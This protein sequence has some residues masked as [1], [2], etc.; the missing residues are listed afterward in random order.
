MLTLSEYRGKSVIV[1]FYLGSGCLHCVEQMQK[2]APRVNDFQQAG[3]SIVGIS[4][5]NL[6]SLATSI[7]NFS[8][9][10]AFPIPPDQPIP[11]RLKQP[12]TLRA[13]FTPRG[14]ALSPQVDDATR[15]F[16]A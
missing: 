7:A 4:T 14:G 10:A 1:I 5:E 6:E 9:T 8:K 11:D 3:I 12:D 13:A 2:F 15:P 16:D